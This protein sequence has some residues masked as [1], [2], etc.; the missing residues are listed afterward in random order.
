[1][2]C[3]GPPRFFR[4][5]RMLARI[6]GTILTLQVLQV[7]CGWYNASKSRADQVILIVGV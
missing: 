5:M 6:L 1:M 7:L 3:V 2:Q 4:L